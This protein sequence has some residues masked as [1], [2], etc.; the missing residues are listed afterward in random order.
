MESRLP[1]NQRVRLHD[2]SPKCEWEKPPYSYVALIAM[3]ISNSST[4]RATLSAI[5]DYITSRFPFYRKNQKGW[6]NSIRHNLSLNECFVKVPRETGWVKKKGNYWMLDP[7]FEGMFE[8]GNYRRRRMV[9]KVQPD[10]VYMPPPYVDTSSG[11]CMPRSLLHRTGDSRNV[12]PVSSYFPPPPAHHFH[13]FLSYGVYHQPPVLLV[14]DIDTAT[15]PVSPDGGTV[16]VGCGCH[17]I[18]AK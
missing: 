13:P 7:S 6:Q 18:D 10:P 4:K 16:P 17:H 1:N 3:A 8:Q 15:Q 14:P 2:M 5:Y 9:K 12:S 11:V